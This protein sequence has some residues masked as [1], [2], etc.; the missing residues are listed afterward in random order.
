MYGCKSVSLYVCVYECVFHRAE[1]VY[2]K[3]GVRTIRASYLWS[4]QDRVARSGGLPSTSVLEL[5]LCSSVTF[6]FI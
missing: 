3:G 2:E 6:G 5:W 1:S 4:T